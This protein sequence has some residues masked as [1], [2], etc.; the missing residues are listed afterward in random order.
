M[1]DGE[2]CVFDGEQCVLDGEQCVL[3]GLQ[4]LVSIRNTGTT[5]QGNGRADG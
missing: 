2:Q 5:D 3:E 4:V 1:L